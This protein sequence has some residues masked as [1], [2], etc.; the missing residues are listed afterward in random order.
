M[1]AGKL[2]RTDL[3]RSRVEKGNIKGVTMLILVYYYQTRK[4]N[5]EQQCGDETFLDK[6]IFLPD[7]TTMK[8]IAYTFQLIN[9]SMRK[10]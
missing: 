7:F 8:L 9:H 5:K 6:M 4:I 3:G 1:L 2:S 10:Y